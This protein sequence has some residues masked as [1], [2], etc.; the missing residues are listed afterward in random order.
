MKVTF[1]GVGEAC[2]SLYPNT[3]LLVQSKMGGHGRQLLLDCGF[4]VPHQYFAS[5]PGAGDLDAV[6]ISHFHGDHFFGIPL[7]LMRLWEMERRKPLYI[8]GPAGVKTKVRQALDLAYPNFAARMHYPLQFR[9]VEPGVMVEV[10]GFQWRTAVGLHSQ[11]AL[12]LR[13]DNSEQSFFYSGDGRSTRASEELANGCALAVHEAYSL[14]GDTPGHGSI[15]GCLEMAARIGLPSLALLHIQRGE[16]LL[17]HREIE[18][19]LARSLST[20]KVWLPEPG[21]TVT[22]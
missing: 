11:R 18:T 8:L 19:Y 21:E 14:A 12:A 1:L 3:S 5:Q 2:D 10:A 22:L 17:A 9:E 13:L 16:R 15:K 7:L 6:W 4:T 20:C